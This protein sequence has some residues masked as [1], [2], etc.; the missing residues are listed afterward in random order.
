M[1]AQ[2]FAAKAIEAAQRGDT[3]GALATLAEAVKAHPR[4][5]RLWHHAGSLMLKSGNAEGA[6]QHF[7]QAFAL[8]PANF[9]FAIDQAIA[10]TTLDRYREAL[11][12]L[13][14]VETQGARHAHYWSTRANAA[15]GTGDFETAS[16][17]YDRALEIEPSRPKALQGRATVALERG[18]EDAPTRFD[19]ALAI[20]Q[21]DAQLWLGKAQA[22][23]VAGRPAEAREIAEALARQ[24]PQWLDAL[25]LLAQ[26]RLGMGEA[27]FAA[28]FR[29][30]AEKLPG[31]PGIPGEHCRQLAALD[32]AEEAMEVAAETRLRF[33]D[34]PHFAMLEAMQAG[35][36]GHDERA[37]AI[38]TSLEYDRVDRHVFE[39][40]HWVRRKD[41]ARADSVLDKALA[42]SPWDIGGWALRDLIWRARGDTRHEWLHGQ[43]GLVQFL[44]LVDVDAVLPDAIKVLEDLHDNAHHPLGQS[45]RGGGTQTRGRLFDRHEPELQALHRSITATLA[46]YRNNLPPADESHPLLRHRQSDWTIFGSWS[47]RFLKGGG[48]HKAHLHPEGLISSACYLQLPD[49]L[50]AGGESKEGWIELGRPAPDIR[51]DLEPLQEIQPKIGYLA[52]FPSTLYHGTRKFKEGR[53]MTVAFDVQSKLDKQ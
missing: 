7:G 43:D 21:G 30:A 35:A 51:L 20:N 10:L 25:R 31:E 38:W 45:L 28:P 16:K 2:Q 18:E 23:D 42:L 39:A 19:K 13:A 44:P 46:E 27:D 9:D 3:V 40:R 6:V 53:R 49:D 34:N 48:H 1:S 11:E 41:F 14:T 52:L 24:F 5:S 47:I 4:E 33:P 32:L 8:E 12:V 17:W 29:E 37:E 15:R 26:L 22:L 36:A 50:G